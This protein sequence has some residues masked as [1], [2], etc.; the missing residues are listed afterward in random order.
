MARITVN[1]EGLKRTVYVD[2]AQMREVVRTL[3]DGAAIYRGLP[4]KTYA[5]ADAITECIDYIH[6][7][8]EEAS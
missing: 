7:E 6:D 3:T 5:L 1:A 8:S 2:E 4:I